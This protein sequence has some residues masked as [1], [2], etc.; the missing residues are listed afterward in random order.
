MQYSQDSAL[1]P[2]RRHSVSWTAVVMDGQLDGEM[3]S[4]LLVK[5]VLSRVQV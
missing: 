3:V 1:G 4:D 2:D 5:S